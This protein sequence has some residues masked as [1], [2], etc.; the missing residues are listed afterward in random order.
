MNPLG[1][2]M[3]GFHYFRKF[4][5]KAGHAKFLVHY[6]FCPVLMRSA[7]ESDLLKP[8]TIGK[9][10]KKFQDDSAGNETCRFQAASFQ[11]NWGEPM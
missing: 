10:L 5:K 8:F 4:R 1:K 7:L 3:C 9:G 6:I 11:R 2:G